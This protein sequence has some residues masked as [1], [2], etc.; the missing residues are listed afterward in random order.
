[1]RD[2]T[3]DMQDIQFEWEFLQIF[4]NLRLHSK[5]TRYGGFVLTQNF[6]KNHQKTAKRTNE[7]K[8]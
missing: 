1:M 6:A 3:N 5:K 2:T 8:S 4:S 7:S